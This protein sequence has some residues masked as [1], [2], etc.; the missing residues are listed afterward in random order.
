MTPMTQVRES[1]TAS[2]TA[3]IGSGKIAASAVRATLSLA[4][5][6]FL[7]VSLATNTLAAPASE[8]IVSPDVAWNVTYASLSG[9]P[10]GSPCCIH[11]ESV[12]QGENGDCFLLSA[13]ATIATESPGTLKNGIHDN[14]DGTYTVSL[15]KDTVNGA[16]PGPLVP[17]TYTIK[18]EFPVWSYL[19]RVFKGLPSGTN[20]IYAKP[21]VDNNSLWTMIYEKAFAEALPDG[22]KTYADGGNGYI[23]MRQITGVEGDYWEVNYKQAAESAVQSVSVQGMPSAPDTAGHS[24]FVGILKHDLAA[25]EPDIQVCIGS[26]IGTAVHRVCTAVCEHAYSCAR[27][28]AYDVPMDPVNPG[29]HI[30]LLDPGRAKGQQTVLTQDEKDPA[31][32]T[33]KSPCTYKATDGTK[34]SMSFGLNIPEEK[35]TPHVITSAKALAATL[36]TLQNEHRPVTLGSIPPCQFI[37]PNL[38]DHCAAPNDPLFGASGSPHLTMQHEYFFKGFVPA[39][40]PGQAIIILGDP[41]FGGKSIRMPLNTFMKAFRAVYSNNVKQLAA[42]GCACK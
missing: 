39:A 41:W 3:E 20:F 19:W 1:Q 28:L 2:M 11:A 25:I 6:L 31:H 7:W 32:C 13:L 23:G 8:S 15:F 34:V 29:I 37:A 4:S 16:A 33:S 9:T 36:S 24:V 12:S 22:Y 14:G 35:N 18:S 17:V 21:G 10:F 26:K 30:E 27:P 40:D 5:L 42:P 38:S